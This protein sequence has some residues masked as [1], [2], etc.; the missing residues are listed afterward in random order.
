[1]ARAVVLAL[2]LVGCRMMVVPSAAEPVPWR[3]T[4]IA[5]VALLTATPVTYFEAALQPAAFASAGNAP[6]VCK[7]SA[8]PVLQADAATMPSLTLAR[9]V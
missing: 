1:M 9:M 2:S 6:F 7:N 5:A 8:T 4:V 3:V